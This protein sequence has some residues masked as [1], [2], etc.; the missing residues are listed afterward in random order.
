MKDGGENGTQ[1]SG[2]NL[3]ASEP[4]TPMAVVA[5][6]SRVVTKVV[7]RVTGDRNEVP[8]MV[9]GAVVE[10]L[11]GYGIDSRIMYGP[12]AWVEILEDQTTMWAGAWGEHFHFW[13]ATQFG[14]V[15]DLNVSVAWRR[16]PHQGPTL[17]SVGSPP[18]LWA[19]E[20]PLFYRYKPEGIAEI[21]LTDEKDLKKYELVLQEVREKCRPSAADAEPE[22]PNEAILCPTRQVLDDSKQSFRHFDR[23]LA[24]FGIPSAPQL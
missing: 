13:V 8:L 2:L 22:F 17:K 3:T 19:R 6:V 10:G 1:V 21:E 16:R 18:I 20:V 9:A 14:E 4:T 11:K 15:V 24:V 12:A 23:A 5:T 7:D